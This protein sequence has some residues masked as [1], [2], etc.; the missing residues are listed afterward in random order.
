V[1]ELI[2]DA[3][4]IVVGFLR[5]LRVEHRAKFSAK[6]VGKTRGRGDERNNTRGNGLVKE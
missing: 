6:V 4:V 3:E 1:R 5:A 2:L